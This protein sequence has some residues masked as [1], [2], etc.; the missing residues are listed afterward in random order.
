MKWNDRPNAQRK[1][2]KEDSIEG[3]GTISRGERKKKDL[4]HKKTKK[5]MKREKRY[6]GKESKK[7]KGSPSRREKVQGIKAQWGWKR[8]RHKKVAAIGE[9]EEY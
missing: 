6:I 8:Q 7:K 2:R 4:L 3:G 1:L 9:N 5:D